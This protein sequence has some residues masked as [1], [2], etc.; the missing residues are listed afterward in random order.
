MNPLAWAARQSGR[1]R[2]LVSA[3]ALT[4]TLVGVVA[5]D[6]LAT[7]RELLRLLREQAEALRHTVAAAVRSN[8]AAAQVAEQQLGAR[9]LESARLLA[10]LDARGALDGPRLEAL[11]ERHGLY[12]VAVFDAHGEIVLR[13]GGLGG[14][15]AG[16]GGLGLG[17]GQGLGPGFRRGLLTRLL[18]GGE[19]EAVT[20][21]HT[22]RW[23][24]AARLAAG[25]RRAGGGAV[26]VNVD[27]SAVEQLGRP[28]S[29]GA[30]LDDV[31]E[32]APGLAYVV[33][34][35][36]GRELARGVPAPPAP[37]SQAE[38]ER[39]QRLASGE[40]ME[41]AG[42]VPLAAEAGPTLR[43]GLRLDSVRRAERRMLAV[44]A[45]TL[46]TSLVLAFMAAGVVWLQRKY[47]LL[48]ARHARAEDALRRRDRLAAMGELASTVAHEVR[49][50]LNAIAMSAQRLR[51]EFVDAGPRAADAADAQSE[52]AELLGVIESEA[53]R[54]ERTVRQFQE[55]ARPKP[56]VP[57]PT[58]LGDLA[59]SVAETLRP[60][61]AA[62]GV[63]L[64]AD[65]ARAGE[66]AIDP[67]LLRQAL[68]NLVRNAL[69]A[70]PG[71]GRV[72]LTARD[73]SAGHVFEVADTGAGI[74][75][76]HLPRLF[77]LYFT[78]KPDGTGVG[79]A[80]TQQ[81]VSAHGGTIEVDSQPG[82]G[83]R[84][85]VRLPRGAV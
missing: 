21:V 54:L 85:T 16:E 62:R 6:F 17:R 1:T 40:V 9:L 39:V 53:Q 58:R 60:R 31:I 56:L 19:P 44:L 78:T 13:S 32:H 49:N 25:V 37:N 47:E 57:R 12:R 15:P 26:V 83:T 74:A 43:L 22:P 46:A 7:R 72:T 48:S 14:G 59:A 64:A 69:E 61:A 34:V 71:G 11:V 76:E 18:E 75:P 81:I 2:V 79:L 29:L 27:A 20:D 38:G 73:D 63:T 50:P 82:A 3:A 5:L 30:L 23:G 55:F 77:D 84:M 51:R 33:L 42:P 8:R 80:V 41:F 4:T 70:T 28:A 24:G 66:A 45:L 68:D 67:D 65:V 52:A 10:E 36:D 35:H